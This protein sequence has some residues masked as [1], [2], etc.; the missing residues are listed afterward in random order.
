MPFK[1][2]YYQDILEE[3]DFIITTDYSWVREVDNII[4]TV[5]TPLKQHIETDISQIQ[6]VIESIIPYLKEKQNIILR[7]TISPGV[8]KYIKDFIEKTTKF[9]IGKNLYLSFC[10]E[11]LAE[12]KAYEELLILPQI[13][14][15]EDDE[16][17]NL[18]KILFTHLTQNIIRTNFAE[19]ELIKLFCNI[20]RY[21]EFGIVNYLAI[22]AESFGC[23]IYELLNKLNYKYP[24]GIRYK[25]G[26]TAGT[27]LRKDFG[28]IN[29][30][31][32]Y[33]DMLLAAWK[34]NE[35]IP[36]FLVNS[37]NN[38]IGNLKGLEVGV[39]GL[40]FKADTDDTRDSLTPKL[41]RYI[42]KQN[43][44]EIYVHDPYVKSTSLNDFIHK[45]DVVFVCV[46]HEIYKSNNKKVYD[47]LKEGCYI[48][49]IW[50]VFDT[51]KLIIRKE[52]EN[53]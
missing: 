27:C 21:M 34:V 32:P 43:P 39:L 42:E 48:V 38:R 9:K 52:P 47:V 8:T 37:I 24:R 23:E 31:I 35:F 11:R 51:N 7:S 16:S 2:P 45:V 15:A 22:I 1:E 30:N 50:N 41:I 10:P 33:S 40:A 49:D 26:L 25:P 28:M 53:E 36:K 12:G 29:E 20:S 5:G 17:F 44:K 3:R 19:A 13:V 14:G 6:N 18:S 4:I 46:N